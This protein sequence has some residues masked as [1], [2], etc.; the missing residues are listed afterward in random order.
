M[1]VAIILPN[2]NKSSY[3]EQRIESILNQ[4]LRDFELIILD[5]C[6]PDNSKNIIENYQHHPKVYHIIYN[7]VNAG[8]TN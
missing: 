8:R 4:S 3:L 5:D 7:E 2:Y 1:K 6:S